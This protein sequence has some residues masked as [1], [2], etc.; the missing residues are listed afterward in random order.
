MKAYDTRHVFRRFNNKQKI[1]DFLFATLDHTILCES[2]QNGP[3]QKG[4]IYT[5]EK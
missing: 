5:Q 1:H 4:R 3:A 2:F